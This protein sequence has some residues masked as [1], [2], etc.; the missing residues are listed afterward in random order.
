MSLEGKY[1]IANLQKDFPTIIST[2]AVID[3][4]L[5]LMPLAIDSLAMYFNRNVFD[6]LAIPTP[7]TT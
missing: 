5:M 4:G 3:D 1:N 6:S 2:E 7:P